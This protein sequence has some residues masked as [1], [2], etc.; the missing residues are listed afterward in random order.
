MHGLDA[1]V[2]PVTIGEPPSSTTRLRSATEPV[3]DGTIGAGAGT[4]ADRCLGAS[5][6]EAGI[7][8]Q[9]RY[10][11][12]SPFYRLYGGFSYAHEDTPVVDRNR[13]RTLSVPIYRELR[14]RMIA[15]V[16]NQVCNFLMA[17]ELRS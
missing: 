2:S 14:A 9:L 11:T 4:K 3:G 15:S 8:T 16:T 6:T 1:P 17:S 7:V 13:S 5:V 12:V 10:P